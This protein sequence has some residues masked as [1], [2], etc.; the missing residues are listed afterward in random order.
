MSPDQPEAI[1]SSSVGL[2][3][4]LAFVRAHPRL[5]VLTGAGVSTE[6]GIPDYRDAA[7][8]WKRRQPVRHQEFLGSPPVRR[9]YWARSM[10]GW[11]VFSRARPN[12]AHQALAGLEAAGR[13]HA[14]LT[15]NVDGL[16][17]AA[18]HRRVIEL[19]GNLSRVVCTG[20]G[21]L[22][23]RAEVQRRLEAGNPWLA[24]RAATPAPDGDAD[25]DEADLERFETPACP[26]CGGILKPDVV[27]FGDSVPRPR[28][29]EALALLAESDALLVAG[30]SLM[31]YSGYRFCERAH[32]LGKP[33]A[34]INLGATR[35]DPLLAVKL[36][37]ACGDALAALS[38]AVGAT[39]A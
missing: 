22:L 15:Q 13:I 1:R 18:G 5:F 8:Q 28:V 3:D 21:G 37:A 23:P 16:H 30:S 31:V 29:E 20:C 25:L 7:G 36:H 19:H 32:A 34:A 35:A 38:G 6:S 26:A 14:L 27:F 10:L 12:G 24:G 9:R 17:Q 39:G 2:A 4:L 11:P 33:I